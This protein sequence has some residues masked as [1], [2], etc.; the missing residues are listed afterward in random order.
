MSSIALRPP[1]FT[2]AMF[3]AAG[4]FL[5]ALTAYSQT[6]HKPGN[7]TAKDMHQCVH[8]GPSTENRVKPKVSYAASY[9]T[10]K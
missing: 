2:H 9:N 3:A 5:F 4:F 8:G 6:L 7:S 10:V 1:H